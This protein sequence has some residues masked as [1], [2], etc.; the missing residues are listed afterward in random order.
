MLS[1]KKRIGQLIFARMPV[2]HFLELNVGMMGIVNTLGP[3][4]RR[5]L[6]R[7]RRPQGA[8]VNVACGPNA[9]AG[10]VNLD[11]FLTAKGV[12]RFDC[13]RWLPFADDAVDGIRVEHFLEHLEVRGGA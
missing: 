12:V 9:L 10:F 4:Q 5:T 1:V 8:L 2:T 6:A 3:A 7:L 13:R 11:L